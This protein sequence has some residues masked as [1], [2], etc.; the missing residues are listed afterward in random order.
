MFLAR[1]DPHWGNPAQMLAE[2][3]GALQE[4]IW[5]LEQQG[6]LKSPLNSLQLDCCGAEGSAPWAD[7]SQ[8]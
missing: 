5:M 7:N 3:L 4:H 8:A 1:A 6:K 2:T